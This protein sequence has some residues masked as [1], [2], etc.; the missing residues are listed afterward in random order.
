MSLLLLIWLAQFTGIIPRVVVL[1]AY[2]LDASIQPA[3]PIPTLQSQSVDSMLR[4][5]G[6]FGDEDRESAD[7]GLLRPRGLRKHAGPSSFRGAGFAREPGIEAHRPKKSVVSPLF[8][9]SG[10]GPDGPSRNDT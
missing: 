1:T 10:P 7:A 5:V 6:E 9:D 2:A 3:I 8:M 4:E